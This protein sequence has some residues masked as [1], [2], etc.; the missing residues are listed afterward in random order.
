[1]RL[2]MPPLPASPSPARV[3]PSWG[4]EV[5]GSCVEV[6]PA[7]K[8]ARE[9][10]TL[11][12]CKGPT[13]GTVWRT[14]WKEMLQTQPRRGGPRPGT[15][16]LCGRLSVRLS[17]RGAPLI[18][19]D[20]SLQG[21]GGGG[22]PF[23]HRWLCTPSAPTAAP[24]APPGRAHGPRS[25]GSLCGALEAGPGFVGDMSAGG[26]DQAGLLSLGPQR[27]PRGSVGLRLGELLLDGLPPRLAV[28]QVEAEVRPLVGRRARAGAA[29]GDGDGVAHAEVHRLHDAL[30]RQLPG[31]AQGEGGRV[32]AGADQGLRPAVVALL[33]VLQAPP[34]G[35]AELVGELQGAQFLRERRGRGGSGGRSRRPWPSPP[36]APSAWGPPFL[37]R[38]QDQEG[39]WGAVEWL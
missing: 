11:E 34:D 3:W 20:L 26:R 36:S 24:R 27:A 31:A 1:M 39:Q 18:S 25:T 38:P 28:R 8:C 29:V 23:G 2:A 37:Q 7:V 10:L 33:E 6:G 35:Q 19:K 30:A 15:R 13:W 4:Q 21:A 16:R 9:R 32:A 14:S 22:R 5:A 17:I 12:S